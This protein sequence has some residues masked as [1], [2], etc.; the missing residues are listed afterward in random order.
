VTSQTSSKDTSPDLLGHLVK[1]Y[2]TPI[3]RWTGVAPGSQQD[4]YL[5][6]S[7]LVVFFTDADE[8]PILSD[9]DLDLFASRFLNVG[10]VY[11]FPLFRFLGGLSDGAAAQVVL[12]GLLHRCR[13]IGQRY[14][15]LVFFSFLLCVNY[16]DKRSDSDDCGCK[17][18]LGFY[19]F[20]FPFRFQVSICSYPISCE[21]RQCKA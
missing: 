19:L 6:F 5:V 17:Y 10:L 14:L 20:G 9:L 18:S 11:G 7:L 2:A 21:M 3:T 13:H 12:N 16:A 4:G 1:S 8:L 15:L